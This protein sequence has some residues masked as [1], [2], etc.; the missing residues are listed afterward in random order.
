MDRAAH[1]GSE[2]VVD[3]LV[4]LDPGQALEAV[5]DDLGAEVVAASGEVLD[6]C[7]RARNRPFDARLQL[8]RGRHWR[9]RW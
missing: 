9:Q 4:L 7:F 8:F 5:R 2:H 1:V 6:A 3:Q